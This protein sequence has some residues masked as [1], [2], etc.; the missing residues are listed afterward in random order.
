MKELNKGLKW[1]CVFIW[2]FV[3]IG[4]FGGVTPGPFLAGAGAF[5]LIIFYLEDLG[6]VGKK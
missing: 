3:L 4:C 5:S 2:L 1:A 6:I